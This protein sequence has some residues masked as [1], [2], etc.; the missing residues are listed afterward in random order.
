MSKTAAHDTPTHIS[1]H[2]KLRWLQRTDANTDSPREAWQ[3][4]Y[5]VGMPN[6]DGSACLHPPTGTLLVH[7]ANELITVL[8]ASLM[9][10]N[11]DHLTTCC[12]CKLEFQPTPDDPAC[13][14]CGSSDITE[15]S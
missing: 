8:R 4:A 10:Y 1:D 7:Q 13:D 3:E 9:D 5:S 6:R 12:N 15:T 11:A 2:A 14:W